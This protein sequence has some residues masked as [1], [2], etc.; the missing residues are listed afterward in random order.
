M[1]TIHQSSGVNGSGANGLL[2]SDAV[3]RVTPM[4]FFPTCPT[5]K[6]K[7]PQSGFSV[8]TL[9]KLLELGLPIDGY[10]LEC[11]HLW[12]ISKLDRIS[13]AKSLSSPRG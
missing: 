2:G 9:R 10:C 3:L 11:D 8:Y 1:S 6:R 4:T 12:P 7:R 5:C 13:L